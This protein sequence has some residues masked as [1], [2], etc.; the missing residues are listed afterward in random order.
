ME[1]LAIGIGEWIMEIG[2]TLL[3][4]PEPESLMAE[5]NQC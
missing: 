3:Y 2:V 4:A 1:M 5:K